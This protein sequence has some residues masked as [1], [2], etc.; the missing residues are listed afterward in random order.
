MDVSDLIWNFLKG[1]YHCLGDINALK[2]WKW[3]SETPLF[4][5]GLPRWCGAHSAMSALSPSA[6]GRLATSRTHSLL[7]Q[8]A[9]RSL[10]FLQLF[11]RILKIGYYSVYVSTVSA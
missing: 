8:A 4:M 7:F 10:L 6:T 3:W 2:G 11:C 5:G 9:E 1:L